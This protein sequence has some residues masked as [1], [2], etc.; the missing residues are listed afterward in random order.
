MKKIRLSVVVFLM[1]MT[2]VTLTA[3]GDN[4]SSAQQT[5]TAQ[6]TQTTSGTSAAGTAGTTS[7]T[8]T[9]AAESSCGV[10]NGIIDDVEQGVND[11]T[12]GNKNT[13]TMASGE[14]NN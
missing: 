7:G 13:G 3:C 9:T 10:I 14:G 2:M 12:G 6:E 4:S 11:M 8:A 1:A 5:T